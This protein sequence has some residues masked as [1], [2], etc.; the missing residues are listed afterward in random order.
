MAEKNTNSSTD[1]KSHIQALSQS[2]EKGLDEIASPFK[3][4][5]RHH[6]A[7]SIVLL[8]A[9]ILAIVIANSHYAHA[10]NSFFET[11]AGLVIG[12]HELK[13]SLHHWINDGLMAMFFFVIGLEIKR[14]IMVGE[15]SQPGRT[16]PVLMAA[17]GGMVFPA[18][19]FLALNISEKTWVGW[20]IPMATD[21]A[22]VIGLLTLLRRYVPAGLIVF[23][24]ALAIIDDIGAILVIAL[25]YTDTLNS[26]YL[27]TSMLVLLI[28]ALLNLFGFRHPIVYLFAG[29][30]LWFVMLKAGIHTTVAGI[31]AALAVPARPRHSPGWFVRRTRALLQYFEFRQRNM[32]HDNNILSDNEQHEIVEKVQSVASQT[33][34]PLQS[35]EHS[36]ERP[37]ALMV[38]PIF[39]LANAGVTLGGV[40]ISNVLH[41][42]LVL[43]I[44]L[45]LVFGK[46]AGIT[47]MCWIVVRLR[48]GTLADGVEL[49]HIIGVGLL[50]GIGFTMSVFVAGLAFESS[51]ADIEAA[52]LG[53]LLASLIAGVSGFLW[54]RI[55]AGIK[56]KQTG[57]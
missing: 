42:P 28:M 9:T 55:A 36:L 54:L 48:I 24:T 27:L 38:L 12:Q 26:T 32:R 22:F 14:E 35:W 1:N 3:D 11:K 34:T 41:N 2:L 19:I 56:Q 29:A 51:A 6:S 7:T 46:A 52:K 31:L 50:A 49:H 45:G 5:I 37:I 40:T 33:I 13:M 20:G 23:I 17:V 47:L 21:T 39:A 25:F 53:I 10:F 16:L 44:V 4:F 8:G 43:G 57:Q 18:A 30:I 15:L